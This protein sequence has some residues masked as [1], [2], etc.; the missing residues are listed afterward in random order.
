MRQELIPGVVIDSEIAFGKPVIAG[1]R[2]PVA[3][4]LGQLAAGVPEGELCAEYE[5]QPEHI[6]AALRYAAWLARQETYH[7]GP[8]GD[9]CLAGRRLRCG[10][11][12]GGRPSRPF[13]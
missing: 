12:A 4:V 1:T 3:L 6:R 5:L 7:A 13:R 2:L 10:R 9:P 8:G 11:H